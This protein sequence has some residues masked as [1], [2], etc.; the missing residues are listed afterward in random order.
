MNLPC[1]SSA[2]K[3]CAA[4][5]CSS[6]PRH[7]FLTLFLCFSGYEGEVNGSCE[8]EPPQSWCTVESELETV[9]SV[10]TLCTAGVKQRDDGD[11]MQVTD[12]S[13]WALSDVGKINN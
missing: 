8:V 6:A 5:V 1:I 2:P 11:T 4:D 10:D 13:S 3:S 9:A 12:S 7:L